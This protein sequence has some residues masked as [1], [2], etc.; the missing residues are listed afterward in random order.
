MRLLLPP[1]RGTRLT[2]RWQTVVLMNPCEYVKTQQMTHPLRGAGDAAAHAVLHEALVARPPIVMYTGVLVTCARQVLNHVLWLPLWH[3]LGARL[4][5]LRLQPAAANLLTSVATGLLVTAINNPLE[6]LRTR[7]HAYGAPA[8][9]LAAVRA[10]LEGG[11]FYSGLQWRLAGMP[12]AQLVS[13]V[14]YQS[15]FKSLLTI[16][17]RTAAPA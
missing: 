10:A 11:G 2:S 17:A 5:P 9:P 14:L 1:L 15:V 7:V 8:A 12:L 4:A 16:V 3:T 6:V 13:L